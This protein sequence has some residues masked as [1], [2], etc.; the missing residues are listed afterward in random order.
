MD[1]DRYGFQCQLGHS[2]EVTEQL[3]A[4]PWDK[5][6]SLEGVPELGLRNCW[7]TAGP[8][9]TAQEMFVNTAGRLLQEA[10]L[11]FPLLVSRVAQSTPSEWALR[12]WAFASSQDLLLLHLKVGTRS[13]SPGRTASWA[14]WAFWVQVLPASRTP[15][16]ATFPCLLLL[17]LPAAPCTYQSRS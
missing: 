8:S 14:R 9:L 2:R 12:P 15:T 1:A 3:R 11:A 10:M 7:L 4:A 6:A 17:G 13:S 16:P 5:E